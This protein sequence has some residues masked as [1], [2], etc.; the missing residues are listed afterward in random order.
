MGNGCTNANSHVKPITENTIIPN[1]N[2]LIEKIEILER[3]LIEVQTKLDI[4][5]PEKKKYT[6]INLL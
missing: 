1:R 4:E 2:E 6:R 5:F 3:K